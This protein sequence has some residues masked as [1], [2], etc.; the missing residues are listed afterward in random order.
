MAIPMGRVPADQ[1]PRE[2]LWRVGA[3]A[4]TDAELLAILL[5]YGRRGESALEM[6]AALLAG[7]GSQRSLDPERGAIAEVIAS[8][9]EPQRRHQ[10]AVQCLGYGAVKLLL[11]DI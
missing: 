7:Y 9:P 10:A 8:R 5:R 3:E 2:R 6:A 11:G 1:R 4:L